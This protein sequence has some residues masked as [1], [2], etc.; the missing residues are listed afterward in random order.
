MGDRCTVEYGNMRDTFPQ[1]TWSAD[2][3]ASLQALMLD[4]IRQDPDVERRVGSHRLA[5]SEFSFSRQMGAFVFSLNLD[6]FSEV[7]TLAALHIRL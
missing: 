7:Q 4:R 3:T 5:F 2:N 6:D 1:N